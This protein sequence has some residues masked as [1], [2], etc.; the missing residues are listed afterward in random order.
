MKTPLAWNNVT[1]N[2]VRTAASLS[3]VMF[4]IVLIFMQ[5]GFYDVCF[6]SST[7]IYDQMDFDIALVSPQYVHLRAATSFS[8]RRIDQ[9]KSVPGVASVTPLY[10]GN[11]LFRNP[12]SR[13]QREIVV[14][15]VDPGAELFKVPEVKENLSKLKKDDTAIMDAV[16]GKGY[17]PVLP[18]MI[19]EVEDRRLEVVGV[20]HYGSGFTTDASMVVSD[21][22]FS[23]MF[24]GYP[25]DQVS[26][27]MVKLAPGANLDSVVRGLEGVLP[28]DVK[29]W[30]RSKL[31]TTEQHF[32]VSLR[33]LGVMFS[34]GVLL[35][36][37]VGAVILYQI[38]ASEIM[39]KLKEYATLKAMGYSN[40]YMNKVVLQQA[41]FFALLGFVPATLM[42]LGMYRITRAATHLPMVMTWQRVV[43]V[44][45]LSV[46]MCSVSGL[47]VS[48]KV[49]RADPADL[50]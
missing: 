29:V 34:F 21:R 4:A 44:L 7:L 48:R 42:A 38:L 19:T 1:Y 6:R 2:K 18:G 39:N 14:M 43:L 24:N 15:A 47:M 12:E 35:A 45:V 17:D 9:A 8:R 28:S 26:V 40:L 50:F 5:L 16:T 32:Y 46:A 13:N 25:L 27:G 49:A 23:R 31:E 41:A 22:T 10:V 20:Y 30:K 11:S 37:A 36:F 33:P 3:G